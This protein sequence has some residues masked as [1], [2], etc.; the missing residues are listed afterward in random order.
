M[1]WADSDGNL[2]RLYITP[3]AYIN[4]MIGLA[5]AAV[6]SQHASGCNKDTEFS[7]NA[8]NEAVTMI[9]AYIK[10]ITDH[11]MSGH[12]LGSK[13]EL[14]RQQDGAVA[15]CSTSCATSCVC[16]TS[17]RAQHPLNY[18]QCRM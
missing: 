2:Y 1:V 5:M 14:F 3:L 12:E 8:R 9:S 13:L 18:L 15:R 7:E 11:V 10:D 6:S 17:S 16:M 4:P